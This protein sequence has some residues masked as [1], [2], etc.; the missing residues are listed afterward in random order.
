LQAERLPQAFPET[1]PQPNGVGGSPTSSDAQEP[2]DAEYTAA[3]AAGPAPR[4][5]TSDADG[6]HGRPMSR[7][8]KRPKRRKIR[9]RD[10]DMI[11][12]ARDALAT[13]VATR[14]P[15]YVRDNRLVRVDRHGGRLS[16]VE[17]EVGH[18][19]YLL[20]DHCTCEHERQG[21]RIFPV[22]AARLILSM[23]TWP[24]PLLEAIT[25]IPVLLPDGT[26]VDRPGYHPSARLLYMPPPGLAVPQV[27]DRPTP[28]QIQ[29]ARDRLFDVI[30]DFPFATQADRANAF[31]LLLSPLLRSL[32][33]GQI[34]LALLDK[35]MPG[36]GATLLGKVVELLA[37][38]A[39]QDEVMTLPR[40][41]EELRKK[42]TAI[43]RENPA[44]IFFDNA[45][46]ALSSPDLM[47]LLTSG[48]WA[49]RLLG[50]SELV[51][52]VQRA[53][54][55]VTG[56]NLQIDRESARRCYQIRMDAKMER[57]EERNPERF[58][59]PDL[60][61]HVTEMRGRL[62]ADALTITR[63]WIQ[64]E[65]PKPAK[66]VPTLGGFGGWVAI[67]GG[68]LAFV[69]IDAFLGNRDEIHTQVDEETA[70]WAHFFALWHGHYGERFRTVA[71]VAKDLANDPTHPF[72]DCLPDD[73]T[74]DFQKGGQ[75]KS[76]RDRFGKALSKRKDGIFS[77]LCLKRGR[78]I[79]HATRW[80]VVK[81]S[82]DSRGGACEDE[83]GSSHSSS[84]PGESG[85]T[86]LRRVK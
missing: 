11:D 53:V 32:V 7:A 56:N 70:Q 64:A 74:E 10:R 79:Q 58:R 16:V 68:V 84:H 14:L 63:G 60:L 41:K 61:N 39:A 20:C 71:R 83:T 57:P 44:I 46:H 28:K 9:T 73:L 42:L 82:A 13:L 65:R 66:K 26:L 81:M 86:G 37:C 8:E 40:N 47:A 3:P 23:P 24:F 77:G 27:P 45:D 2:T 30:I 25:E 51:H 72:H 22:E 54:W 4:C 80:R 55:L 31:A 76:F 78:T 6:S 29:C 18:L 17:V 59:H 38:G 36:T 52:V 19:Y 62:I 33:P 85:M 49:D 15:L 12:V 75:R 43:L 50:Y 34:P 35:P 21:T 5:G 69:G 1:R 48:G 67:H